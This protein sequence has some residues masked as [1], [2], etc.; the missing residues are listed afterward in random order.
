MLRRVAVFAFLL[1]V[2]WCAYANAQTKPWPIKVVI[3][4]SFEIGKDTGDIPGEFQ[5][6][7]EREHLTE[8][9]EFAGG[10]HPILTNADHSVIGIVSGT[11]LVNA[12]ASVMA[13]GLDPRFDLTH[14]Y[15]LI[16][17]I[18][19]VDPED[20][21]IGSA[22]WVHYTVS[23]ISRFIDPREMPSDWPYGYFTIGAVK[24]NE[25]PP[26]NGIIH[27]RQ[28]VYELNGALTQWAYEQ[29]K[30]VELLDVDAVKTFRGEY[31]GYPNAQ[32]PP[33]VLVGDTYA[34]DSYWHGAKM[35]Q[36]ANEW[37]KLFTKGH[38]QFVMTDM[39]DSG[40]AEALQRLDRMHRV[41]YQRVMLLRTGSN[42]SMP[43]PGHTAVE[44][45]T[46]PYIGTRPAVE[47]AF[48]VGDVVVREIL[49]HWTLYANK[50]PGQ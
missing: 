14:A 1:M 34:S 21:S 50:I 3:V 5:L 16:N 30:G 7:V 2:G 25:L 10:V 23:D 44:S 11:T 20:A 28:N 17:G 26:A 18:A 35:T 49:A 24:P 13:L 9:L 8:S 39:E 43:R 36:Y 47:N 42:Y 46:A 19:G 32:R 37:V 48:R 27:D 38:G 40:Y 22:A 29:T 12:T 41:D 15:W 45:V 31:K 4:T 33:F 6:W